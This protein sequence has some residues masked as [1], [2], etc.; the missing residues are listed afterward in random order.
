MFKRVS[1]WLTGLDPTRFFLLIASVFG[2]LFLLITPPFQGADEI[3]H[4]YRG[5]QVSEFNLVSDQSKQGTGGLLPKSLGKTVAVT[6]SPV[7][8]FYPQNKYDIYKTNGELHTPSRPE[9]KKFYNFS[10]SATY[11]PVPYAG[12][13]SG[14]LVARGLNLPPVTAMHAGRL[15]NLL[16]WLALVAASI[17]SIP[18]RK[19]VLVAI[20]LLP[21]ALFQASTLNGDAITNGSLLLFIA[22]ILKYRENKKPLKQRQLLLL[23]LLGIIMVLSKQVMF[24]FLPLLF[25]LKKPLFHTVKQAYIWRLAL[26]LVPLIFF[27]IWMYLTRGIDSSNQQDAQAQFDFIFHNPHSFINVLWNTYFFT[28]GDSII[29]SFIGVFGWADAPLSELIVLIGYLGLAI[30]FVGNYTPKR[31]AWLNK[32]E[33]LSIWLLM[34]LY[35][36]AVSVSLYLYYSP[37]GFKIIYG[38]QGRYFIPIAILAVLVV[39]SNSIKISRQL[40]M[41]V[42]RLLPIFLLTASLITIYV[43]YFVSN[44]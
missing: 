43:R 19:W 33:Q 17:A 10:S 34:A 13:S 20:G 38:L 24:I 41:S 21:M 2:L 6:N 36:L 4:F 22:L 8:A 3:V 23:M 15:G 5:Y 28:W 16:A 26:G 37:V 31:L 39:Q 14:I 42:A 12:V 11:S 29:R 32:R 40:Y 27:L 25:L 44:V 30:L 9:D 1:G 18:R 35:F 7:I